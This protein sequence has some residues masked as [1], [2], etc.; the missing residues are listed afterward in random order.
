MNVLVDFTPA[1]Q[2][3]HDLLGVKDLTAIV[4]EYLSE[5]IKKKNQNPEKVT[6][7]YLCYQCDIICHSLQIQRCSK[8][9]CSTLVH[10]NC[11][12]KCSTPKCKNK[13]VRCVAHIS[14][15][16]TCRSC[17][18]T[19]CS[20][21]GEMDCMVSC[22]SCDSDYCGT[23]CDSCDSCM[24]NLCEECVEICDR[25]DASCCPDCECTCRKRPRLE[26]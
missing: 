20:N 8:N 15:W 13:L 16:G 10:W 26:Q 2:D 22:V 25:C 1:I 9:N 6:Y 21:C 18:V 17:R 5:P 23:D 11:A 4:V 14:I 7:K 24:E 12:P 19:Q 3:L